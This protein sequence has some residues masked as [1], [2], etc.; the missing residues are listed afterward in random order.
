MVN[1]KILTGAKFPFH[2]HHLSVTTRSGQNQ[3][4]VS[5]PYSLSLSLS[6]ICKDKRIANH[7]AIDSLLLPPVGSRLVLG[8]HAEGHCQ[9]RLPGC[10]LIR[11][12]SS[13]LFESSFLLHSHFFEEE[14]E[15]PNKRSCIIKREPGN[16][17][18]FIDL[19]EELNLESSKTLYVISFLF[20]ANGLTL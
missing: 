4:L 11:S 16:L 15:D 18:L 1:M 20:L 13:P 12:V 6:C 8:V 3:T 5:S 17:A 14:R 7:T 9:N 2:T 10:L 19:N